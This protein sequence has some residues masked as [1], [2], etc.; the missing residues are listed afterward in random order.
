MQR[1]R[2]LKRSDSCGFFRTV[3]LGNDES[4]LDLGKHILHNDKN[5][6]NLNIE[7]VAS[8]AFLRENRG[9]H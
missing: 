8:A 2:L 6:P 4:N 3:N 9:V 5:L 7:H 1:I